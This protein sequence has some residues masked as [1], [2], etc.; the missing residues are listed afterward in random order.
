MEK[1][2]LSI[3]GKSFSCS[4]GTSLLSAAEQQGIKIPRLCHHPQLEPAGACRL[5]LVEDEKTGRLMAS[6]VTPAAP[7][8]VIRTNTLAIK[9]HRTNIVRLMMA[10]HPESCIVC[11]KGNRCELRRTAAEL[12]IGMTGL[13]PMPHYTG[14]E[15]ANP[16]IVRDLSKCILCGKCI[17]ACNELVVI[18][19]IDYNLRG[20]RSRPA[21]AHDMPLEN[22]SCT[23][24]GT[25]VSLCPTGAL[26]LKN[27]IP[28][29]G[30]PEGECFSVCGLCCVGC[31]LSVG[32]SGE[33]IVS[34]NPSPSRDTA[35]GVTLCAW[36]RFPYDLLNGDDRLT[37]P[38][39][40]KEGRPNPLTWE[41]AIETVSERFLDIKSRYGPESIA[42]LSSLTCTNE[43]IYLFQKMARVLFQTNNVD[44][45]GRATAQPFLSLID[46]GTDGGYRTNSLAWLE[47]RAEMIFVFGNSPSESAPVVGYYLRRAARKGIPLVIASYSS[48]DLVDFS[49]LWLPLDPEGNPELINGLAS[50]LLKEGASDSA[51]IDRFSDGFPQYQDLLSSINMEKTS[52]ATGLDMTMLKKAAGLMKG[53]KI[54]F[55]IGEDILS[56]KDGIRTMD[57]LYNLSLMTGSLGALGAGFYILSKQNN[58]VGAYD[59]GAVP[60]ALP[61]RRPVRDAVARLE[62]EHIWE[63]EIPPSPGLNAFQ[64]IDEAE[65]GNIKALYILGDNLF[66]SL[67]DTERLRKAIENIEF[68][69]MQCAHEN[70]ICFFANVVLPG[71][72]F[73]EKG[74]SFTNMEGRV[75]RFGPVLSPPGDARPDWEILGLLYQKLG[76]P[77]F[78]DSYEKIEKEIRHTVPM[79]GD[80]KGERQSWLKESSQK[81]LFHVDGE[82]DPINFAV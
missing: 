42:F 8:M 78:Y 20:F 48:T 39:I 69:V 60:D 46:E 59:M 6:C 3:D 47:K 24:C 2:A 36:G 37:T 79:Y 65:K 75:Q 71:A 62:W 11:N 51:F 26:S 56:G 45:V 7:D 67:T 50:I 29:T 13:Y 25:C 61:G 77:I 22:S 63:R 57:A 58:Q 73:L 82:G 35:N 66:H 32:V 9:K 31:A 34:I 15:E 30:T 40:L 70:E 23:F 55:V 10:N 18:G 81:K 27:D 16:F 68:T 19:A 1:I 12:G 76:Y 44:N 28:Y 33:R 14:L 64:M 53:K 72:F 74:G 4:P 49:S 38:Q 54:A 43:E 17:R 80:L 41:E 21:T 52:Q 5:C